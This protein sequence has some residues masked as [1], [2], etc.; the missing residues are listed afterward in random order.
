MLKRRSTKST[1]RT[2]AVLAC[3]PFRFSTGTHVT[4]R[5][6]QRKPSGGTSQRKGGADT[7]YFTAL[8]SPNSSPKLTQASAWG[9]WRTQGRQVWSWCGKKLERKTHTFTVATV[10]VVVK[11]N[12]YH[13]V[14]LQVSWWR[15]S[16]AC[17][18]HVGSTWL[19]QNQVSPYEPLFFYFP[20]GPYIHWVKNDFPLE[21]INTWPYQMKQEKKT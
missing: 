19:I 7:R 6:L 1:T 14:I 12:E 8:Q 18:L 5:V 4:T 15:W 9:W 17:L 16:I 10:R 3:F 13:A 2:A 21:S 11:Y 20:P